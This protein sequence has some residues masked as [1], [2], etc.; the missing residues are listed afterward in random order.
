MSDRRP[1]I[2]VIVTSYNYRDYITDAI[3]S[4]L[5]QT[6]PNVEAVVVDNASTDGTVPF[7]RERYRD[8]PR[9]RIFANAENIGYFANSNRGFE[10][11]RGELVCWLSADDWMYPRHL[12]RLQAAFEQHPDLDVVYAGAYF[13]D[14]QRRVLA[15]RM[16][17]ARFPFAYVD[18]RDELVDMLTSACPMCWPS[19]LFRRSVFDDVGLQDPDGGIEGTDWEMGVR[20]ALAGK[21]FAYLPDPSI[22]IRIH[23][24]QWT[25]QGYLAS[26]RRVRDFLQI[27]DKFAD[28]PGMARMR[29]RER[30]IAQ[31]L[32][33]I[34][35]DARKE[36]GREVFDEAMRARIAVKLEQLE[37]AADAYEPARVRESLVSV[38]LPVSRSPQLTARAIDSVA[39]QT[40][41]RWE[42]LLLDA[43]PVSLADWLEEQPN[44]AR[45]SYVRSPAPLPPRRARNLGFRMARGEYFA[46]LNEDDT[47][48]PNHLSTLADTIVRRGTRVAAA[49]AGLV[50][51]VPDKYFLDIR[52]VGRL[53]V[54]LGPQDSTDLN[55]VA[56]ALPLDAL[57]VHR[58]V[59][60][61]ASNFGEG[62]PILDDYEFVL[63]VQRSEAIAFSG[64]RTLD[65]RARV[66]FS[67]TLGAHLPLYLL[68]LDAVYALHLAPHLSRQR[69][70]HRS[71][72]E[73]GIAAVTSGNGVT[74]EKSAALLAT[75][76]GRDV[77]PML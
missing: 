61:R 71:A 3:D 74:V 35:E 18:A 59:R 10:L 37:A 56:N 16:E 40:F 64:E 15:Q 58:S 21:R 73:R 54:F 9:V 69:A 44:R 4:I 49:S 45:I 29:G 38:L 5:A 50:L 20:I 63:S 62:A 33:L 14:A 53:D 41:P 30:G 47:F 1:L 6:Y 19:T 43:G 22:A 13:A 72:V 8:D 24:T 76:A 51:E 48:A 25:G 31:F 52:E 42:L 77:R 7:L 36:A 60:E 27:L 66:D 28:H 70:A 57:L 17:E 46:F 11:S 2:S 65:V 32:R 34:V 12:E 75:L 39:R 67:T 23:A 26:D 68:A 55:L